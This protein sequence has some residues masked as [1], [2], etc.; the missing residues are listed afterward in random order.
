MLPATPVRVIW[1][2]PAIW[3]QALQDAVRAHNLHLITTTATR[4]P[5][6][7]QAAVPSTPTADVTVRTTTTTIHR[8]AHGTT[9]RAALRPHAAAGAQAVAECAQPMA[10]AVDSVAVAT[11][12]AVA[13]AVAAD[14]S[15][16]TTR[17]FGQLPSAGY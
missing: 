6:Q 15:E 16:L 13:E 17:R 8:T 5:H 1:A 10:R 4:A 3:A 2:V 7:A 14:N 12:A 11:A 9:A